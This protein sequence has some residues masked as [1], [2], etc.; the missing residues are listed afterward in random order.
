MI[1]PLSLESG[2]LKRPAW[3]SAMKPQLNAGTEWKSQ[4][5]D[6]DSNRRHPTVT[7]VRRAA[8]RYTHTGYI[9]HGTR[10][11]CQEE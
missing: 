3:P 7:D 10:A 6:E 2:A 5:L 11:R 9:V 8:L 1:R 4:P